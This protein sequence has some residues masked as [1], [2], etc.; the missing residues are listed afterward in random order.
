MRK[1]PKHRKP[2]GIKKCIIC[3]KTFPARGMGAHIRQIHGL[4]IKTIYN[5]ISIKDSTAKDNVTKVESVDEITES[6]TEIVK[7]L[8]VETDKNFLEYKNPDGLQICPEQD[9]WILFSKMC[10]ITMN[11]DL[12]NL[13][14]V[15]DNNDRVSELIKDFERRFDCILADVKKAYP[16]VKPGHTQIEKYNLIKRYAS[17]QYSR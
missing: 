2:A 9:V 3:G 4:V 15:F 8:S 1:Y 7:K 6:R 13:L 17:L 5:Y 10:Q 14:S 16:N 11:V 12:G